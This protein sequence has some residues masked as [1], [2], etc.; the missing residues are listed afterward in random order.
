MRAI[1]L[2]WPT[3]LHLALLGV[4]LLTLG[5]WD[6]A[7]TW[8]FPSCPFY[9]MTGW[10]CPLCGSLRA[11]HAMLVGHPLA[12]LALNPLTIVGLGMWVLARDRTTRFCFSG[13]GLTLLVGF[14]LFRN[15]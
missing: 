5:V 10:L 13:P 11:V 6:P 12:A 14:G 15:L 4:S 8:W 7:T 3:A 9:A 1:R 2:H